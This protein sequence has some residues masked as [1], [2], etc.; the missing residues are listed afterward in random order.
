MLS[1]SLNIF[2]LTSISSL[3]ASIIKSQSLNKLNHKKKWNIEY[4]ETGLKTMTG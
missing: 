1:N 3:T 2:D 4:V